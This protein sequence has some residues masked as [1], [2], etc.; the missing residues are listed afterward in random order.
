LTFI[1]L[2]I[3]CD[4]GK[5]KNILSKSDMV[6]LLA[7]I[8]LLDAYL[9]TLPMDSSRQVIEGL[10]AETFNHH[11]TDSTGFRS[12]LAYYAAN[13]HEL[14][15]MYL[16]VEK[17][18]TADNKFYVDKELARTDSIRHAD[19]LINKQRMD[20]IARVNLWNRK[21]DWAKKLIHFEK[22]DSLQLDYRSLNKSFFEWLPFNAFEALFYQQSIIAQGAEG[23]EEMRPILINEPE[24]SDAPA[25][26]ERPKADARRPVEDVVPTKEVTNKQSEGKF[27]G[28]PGLLQQQSVK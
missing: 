19:S 26:Q 15:A 24:Q 7:D 17:K 21:A 12:S 27:K 5:D 9:N 10:Y 23:I 18:L 8:H 1:F 11:H 2:L 25:M 14:N 16:E 4:Q 22:Q 20:S 6:S 28:R 3:S 13:T